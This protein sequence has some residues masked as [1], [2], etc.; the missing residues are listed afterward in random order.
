[1]CSWRA[2]EVSLTFGHPLMNYGRYCQ[3][4]KILSEHMWLLL[5][6]TTPH[7]SVN[8]WKYVDIY[9]I[10]SWWKTNIFDNICFHNNMSKE[11]D[12]F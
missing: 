6:G 1:M 3:K 4:G 2:V 9:D 7:L 8:A 5:Q 12:F 11:S 10:L